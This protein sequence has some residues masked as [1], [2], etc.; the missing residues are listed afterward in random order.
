M[1]EV[2]QKHFYKMHIGNGEM[3]KQLRAFIALP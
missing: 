1:V 2:F 3:A